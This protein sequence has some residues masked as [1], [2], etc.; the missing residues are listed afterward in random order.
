MK[1]AV[2]TGASS[3]IG[4]AFVLQLDADEPFDEI[5]A[6]ALEEDLLGE[7][8]KE[9]HARIRPFAMDFCNRENLTR[10]GEALKAVAPD[11]AVLVNAS[12]FGIFKTFEKTSLDR[13]FGMVDVNA[14]TMMGMTYLTLPYM[15]QGGRIY[16]M[17]SGSSFQPTPYALIYGATKAFALSF[18]RGLNVEFRNGRRG[19]RVMAVCPLWV[20][21]N[22]FKMAVSDKTISYF[23]KWVEAADVVKKAL[24][25]MRRG[26]DVSILGFNMQ[27]QVL[28]VKL[29]PAGLVMKIWCKQQKQG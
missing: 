25:D 7:L 14:R 5:W 3:G 1:I 23:S 21:T 20:K 18:S 2:V 24:K 4:R 13:L 29:L 28:G 8:Q 19:I 15:R 16:N 22:F 26:K 6:I 12:G 9:V 11:V 17:G 10:Y 27:M